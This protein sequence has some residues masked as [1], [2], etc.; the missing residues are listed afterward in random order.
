MRAAESTRC[1]SAPS[2]SRSTTAT[3][4][5]QTTPGPSCDATAFRPFSSFPP[6]IRG[7]QGRAFWWD[8]LYG[9]VSR[10]SAAGTVDD[11]GRRASLGVGVRPPGRV[12]AASEHGEIVASRGGD[13]ARGRDLRVARRLLRPDPRSSA[14]RSSVAS[15]RRASTWRLT[16]ELTHSSTR[17][18]SRRRGPRSSDRSRISSA[19]SGSGHRVFAYPAGGESPEV[20]RIL[21]EEGFELAFSA[22]RGTND[23]RTAD[24]LRLRRIN[25]GRASAVPLVRAQLL[26]RWHRPNSRREVYGHQTRLDGQTALRNR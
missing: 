10:T 24:W 1:R 5:S 7:T 13:D 26:P 20:A 16:L 4:T 3:A 12:S 6:P 2:S 25:V 9:A 8:R 14:G 18:R 23:I 11:A 15:S 22:K 19:R 21:E 17:C